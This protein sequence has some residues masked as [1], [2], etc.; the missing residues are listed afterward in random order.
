MAKLLFYLWLYI[1]CAKTSSVLSEIFV[2]SGDE[3][4]D[5]VNKVQSKMVLTNNSNIILLLGNTGSG[6]STLIHYV[7][8]DNSKMISIEPSNPNA[9]DLIIRDELDPY[10]DQITTT[11]QSRTLIPEMMIDEEQYVWYDTPGFDDTR[12]ETVEIAIA[13]LIKCVI[14]NAKNIKIVLVVNHK[15]VV[16][17]E[18]RVDFD[19]LLTQTTQLLKNIK[20]FKNSIS[21]VVT[22]AES[23]KILR[24][25]FITV[26]EDNVK[27]TTANFML[28]H[29]STLEKKLLTESLHNKKL[30]E[31]KIQLIN[32]L[33]NN[34][35]KISVFWRPD[36]TGSFNTIPIMVNGR[37]FIRESIL[38]GTSY[39]E[40]QRGDFGYPLTD[41]AQLKVMNLT[42]QSLNN[43]SITLQNIKNLISTHIKHQIDFVQGFKERL[44]MIQIGKESIESMNKTITLKLVA[45][46][47]INL[48]HVFNVTSV[49]MDD[50]KYIE[51]SEKSFNIFASLIDSNISTKPSF[52]LCLEQIFDFFINCEHEIQE[53]IRSR[54]NQTIA[55]IS[56]ILQKIDGQLIVAIQKRIESI[57]GLHSRL[58]LLQLGQ[59]SLMFRQIN[60]TSESTH[61]ITDEITLQQRTQQLKTL[62][63]AFNVTS[64]KLSEF[65]RLDRH[66]NYLNTLKSLT[67]IEF[68]NFNAISSR[69][70]NYQLSSY[71]W[72]SFLDDTYRLLTSYDVQK[73]TNA[74]N[75]HNLSDW[76]QINKPGNLIISKKN[77]REFT[78][79]ITR[80]SEFMPTLQKLIELN[81]II[82]ITLKSAPTYDCNKETMTVKGNVIKSSDIHLNKCQSN[83]IKY[84]H[85]YVIDTFYIDCDLF[86]NK[87]QPIDLFILANKWHIREPTTFYLN[88]IN[89]KPP[90]P[91][92]S[93]NGMVGKRGNDGTDAGN[94]FGIAIE[95]LNGHL[96]TIE[97]NGGNGGNG[98]DGT[99]SPDQYV[100]FDVD[101]YKDNGPYDSRTTDPDNYYKRYFRENG[102]DAELKNSEKA[103]WISGVFLSDSNIKQKFRLFPAGCCGSI[104]VGGE[105]KDFLSL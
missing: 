55:E 45:E 21:L 47:L 18:N 73:N 70:I 60:H 100:I 22:K 89:G 5:F 8:G 49:N 61:S 65:K 37:H 88:G 79:R 50:F 41:G 43:I 75:V 23:V 101:N 13:F 30:I 7:A 71:E 9:K 16:E 2:N 36:D 42:Q 80:A 4:L 44:Q 40:T 74:Y 68:V 39:V 27:N 85:V 58:E 29:R 31:S 105:G 51:R 94:F 104:G 38:N 17:S 78:K 59:D 91:T 84:I 62:I 56:S 102:Y 11:T 82:D 24:R 98:Q 93:L 72:Y 92:S 99:G 53:V 46:N 34:S 35:S 87:T 86:L 97:L 83:A 90:P 76:G 54:A 81:A 3:T 19:N 48:I 26:T 15:S 6:K 20:H 1:F 69:A 25:K 14:E 64:I 66:T 67:P 103:S 77:F 12:N 63:Q 52:K 28:D 57:D 96:L 10:I 95:I 33:V 32:D